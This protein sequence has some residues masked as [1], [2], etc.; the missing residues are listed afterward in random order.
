MAMR[1]RKK[2]GVRPDEAKSG[3]KIRVDA[4][5]VKIYA[6]ACTILFLKRYFH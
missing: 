6:D 1:K 2:L 3:G 5:P 4:N